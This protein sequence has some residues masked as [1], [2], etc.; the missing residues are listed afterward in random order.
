MAGVAGDTETDVNTDV[1]G[2]GVGSSPPPPQ[3]ATAIVSIEH[4]TT[5]LSMRAPF[6]E[7]RVRDPA[8]V[9]LSHL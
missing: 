8:G 2:G 6:F 1:G 7:F 5:A 9:K 3:A 4:A